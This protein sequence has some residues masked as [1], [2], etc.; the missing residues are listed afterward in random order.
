MTVIIAGTEAA[1]GPADPFAMT[2]AELAVRSIPGLTGWWKAARFVKPV[3]GFR[4]ASRLG[5]E[6]M[7]PYSALSPL[8]VTG[9]HGKPA[10]RTG[11]GNPKFSG[12]D[13]GSLLSPTG[14]KLLSAA[15]WTVLCVYRAPTIASGEVTVQGGYLWAAMGPTGNVTPRLILSRTTGKTALTACGA[16]ISNPP[17][18]VIDGLWHVTLSSHDAATNQLRVATDRTR[19][20]SAITT[21][22]TPTPDSA[23]AP[24]LL[25]QFKSTSTQPFSGD[26]AEILIFNRKITTQEEAVAV[27]NYLAPEYGL[28]LV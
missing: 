5:L 23:T 24:L 21:A 16:A 2:D 10:L 18:N 11:Y 12:S 3:N 25:A 17:G 7:I 22:T 9:S 13:V 8:M 26:L 4:W 14:L 28:S 27:D 20:V 6:P 1:I 19:Y 15:G